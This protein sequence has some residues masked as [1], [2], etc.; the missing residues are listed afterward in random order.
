MIDPNPKGDV[1]IFAEQEDGVLSDV[2]LELCS[3]ARRLADQLGVKLGAVLAGKDT[4]SPQPLS[5]ATGE[6]GRGE[7]IANW[8]TG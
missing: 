3:K 5:P 2:P 7:G 4:P 6:R 1:W 8:P